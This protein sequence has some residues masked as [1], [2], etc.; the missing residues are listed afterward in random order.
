MSDKIPYP[1]DETLES[2]ISALRK[3]SKD[4]K[5]YRNE[6]IAM[7]GDS[8]MYEHMGTSPGSTARVS[9]SRRAGTTSIIAFM[10]TPTER[11]QTLLEKNPLNS[12]AHTTISKRQADGEYMPALE[13]T[14]QKVAQALAITIAQALEKELEQ[15]HGLVQ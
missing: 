9:T 2:A 15:P 1:T 5:D 8:M 12:Y 13:T 6:V 7:P 3:A 10:D 11:Y 14:N 4:H